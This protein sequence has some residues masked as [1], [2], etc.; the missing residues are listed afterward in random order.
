[1]ASGH[2]KILNKEG[3]PIKI[4]HVDYP[5]FQPYKVRTE[6]AKKAA[7]DY[8]IDYTMIQPSQ[9]STEAY[10]EAVENVINQGFDAIIIEPWDYDAFR[11]VLELAKEKGIAVVSVHQEYPD[12][13]LVI[14]MLYINNEAYGV[15]AADEL[16]TSTGGNANVLMMMNNASIPNQATMRQSFIDA[17]SKSWPNIK[18]IDTQFTNI[19]SITASRVLEASLKAYP[20]IDT[21]IWLEGATVTTGIDVVKEMGYINNVKVIGID[22]PPDVITSIGKGEAWGSFNQNFQK[23]GYEAVRNIADYFSNN[24]FPKKTDC[25]IV[26]ITKENWNNYL[27]DMWETVATKGKAY[28]FQ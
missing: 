18:V 3:D 17:T 2:Q 9:V 19:D 13:E 4:V 8:G 24:P 11:P 16:G 10:V 21:A 23:Q 28:K 27:P 12:P 7:V 14:S 5:Q 22:D 1:M 6:S 15:S 26:L 20:E 25:G